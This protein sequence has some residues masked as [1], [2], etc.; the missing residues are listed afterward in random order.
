MTSRIAVLKVDQNASGATRAHQGAQ[1]PQGRPDPGAGVLL[2]VYDRLYACYGPQY[3]WPGESRLEIIVGAILTQSVAW[4]NVEQAIAN[5]KAAGALATPA[6]LA[7]LSQEELAALIRPAG[8][9]NAKARKI[10]AFLNYLSAHYDLQL[11]RFCAQEV[12]QLRQELL[13]VWG[14]G[15]ETADAILLYVAEKPVFVVDA[16]TKRLFSRLGLVPAQI[17]YHALQAVL[18]DGLPHQVSLFQEYHALI[19]RHAV[20]T[21][22]KQQPSCASCPL[23]ATCAFGMAAR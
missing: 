15:P 8:Y 18:M 10:H 22:R 19:V 4:R 17:D 3:W 2:F 14:I 6:T 7:A 5:L 23:L 11:D 21:C 9:Y 16:Y 12:G 20:L 1:P 13:S